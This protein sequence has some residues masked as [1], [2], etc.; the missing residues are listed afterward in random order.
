MS[1]T[2]LPIEEFNSLLKKWE[3]EDIKITKYEKND[4]D[5]TYLK[6]NKVAYDKKTRRIDDYEPAYTLQLN[7]DGKVRVSQDDY[8]PLPHSLYEI[9]LEDETQYTFDG[10]RFSINTDRG[11][12]TIETTPGV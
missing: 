10:V 8:E 11:V 4:H 3:G 9:P 7:G 2:L 5:E 1:E 12:Y 6:L